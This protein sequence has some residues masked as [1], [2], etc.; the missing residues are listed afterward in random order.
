M[1]SCFSALSGVVEFV[2]SGRPLVLP[3][4]FNGKAGNW[5]EWTDQLKVLLR[6]ASGILLKAVKARPV[7]LTR[8][9]FNLSASVSH[10]FTTVKF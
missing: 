6:V 3:E 10:P 1:V 4:T 5:D 2:M 8:S 9:H 7:N